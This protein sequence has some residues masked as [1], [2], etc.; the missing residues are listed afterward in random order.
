MVINRRYILT[1]VLVW[2]LHDIERG[3]T[4][5]ELMAYPDRK[6]FFCRSGQVLNSNRAGEFYV[7]ELNALI[8][9]VRS[10][11]PPFSAETARDIAVSHGYLQ[12]GFLDKYI[13]MCSIYWGIW[14]AYIDVV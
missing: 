7:A 2:R 12:A 6:Q 13:E 5:L 1:P 14:Q 11:A 9:Q 3:K 4:I 10:L 8:G